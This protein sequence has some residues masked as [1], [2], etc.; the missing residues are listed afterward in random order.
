[1]VGY[2]KNNER[3]YDNV[4]TYAKTLAELKDINNY[5]Y[6]FK[7]AR[8]NIYPIGS[9]FSH[10][11]TGFFIKAPSGKFNYPFPVVGTSEYTTRHHHENSLHTNGFEGTGTIYN[12]FIIK[13]E[14]DLNNIRYS[15]TSAFKL[16]NNITLTKSFV[17]IGDENNTVKGILDGNGKRISNINIE[18][19][20][21]DYVGLFAFNS[22][23]IHNVS[24]D[25]NINTPNASRVGGLA[26]FN[27]GQIREVYVQG[28]ITG[29]NTVGGITGANELG[30]IKN[31]FNLAEIRGVTDI[32]GIS[33][34]NSG[35]IENVYSKTIPVLTNGVVGNVG[36]IVGFNEDSKGS[37]IIKNGYHITPY[38]I[39]YQ[40]S[41]GQPYNIANSRFTSES[42]FSKIEKFQ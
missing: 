13:N 34:Y 38:Q 8:T 42:D 9:T 15:L 4:K 14:E 17:P 2:L 12:P 29:L 37:G 18:D 24:L 22:G 19:I 25:V 32:G 10:R 30:S 20:N 33:G 31:S 28:Q 40:S 5:D 21:R 6:G 23:I 16:A 3:Y 11:T 35:T 39:G 26:G 1:N 36:G 7:T 27:N 41:I